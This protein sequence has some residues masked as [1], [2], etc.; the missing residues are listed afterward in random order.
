MS[1]GG[2]RLEEKRV[3]DDLKRGIIRPKRSVQDDGAGVGAAPPAGPGGA[4]RGAGP[5]VPAPGVTTGE[6]DQER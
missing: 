1:L 3:A 6:S 2:E 4:G 5:V